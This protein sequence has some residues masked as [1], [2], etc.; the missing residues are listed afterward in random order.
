MT[1]RRIL[2][3]SLVGF[4]IF[5]LLLGGKYIYQKQ[6]VDVTILS[7]SQE[8]PG[9]VSAKVESHNGLKEM[10]VKTNQLTN[11]RQACQILKKVAENVP[12][13]F[14]DSRNQTLERVLGQMQF[15]VQEGIA[16]GNFTVMAQNLR[17]QA[18]N[19]DVNLELEMDSDA[20]YLILNQ[21]PAQLIEVIERNGQGEFLS[22][23]KD[24]G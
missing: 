3:I 15:A 7:Q 1:N 17:T 12:I 18:E 8:I 14:I 5:G 9:V 22:S 4:L 13:R 24:M 10:V 19:E 16:S 2:L 21:G 20:I 11:L 23:E 6:W